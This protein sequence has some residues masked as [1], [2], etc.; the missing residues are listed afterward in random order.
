MI[1]KWSCSCCRMYQSGCFTGTGTTMGTGESSAPSRMAVPA[2]P[3]ALFQNEH[4]GR[5]T[6]RNV[7][8]CS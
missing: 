8:V 2:G 3:I 7:P 6:A 4:S 5:I 1:A